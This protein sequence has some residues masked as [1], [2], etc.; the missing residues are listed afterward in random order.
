MTR[1]APQPGHALCPD[2]MSSSAGIVRRAMSLASRVDRVGVL[3][4]S[5]TFGAAGAAFTEV[6]GA[7]Y[8]SPRRPLLRDFV[9][10]LGGRDVTEVTVREAFLDLLTRD[11][12]EPQWVELKTRGAN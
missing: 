3:D 7:Q 9:A 5:F 1:V 12:S 6:A 10:G 11:A 2:R 8:S 4:R